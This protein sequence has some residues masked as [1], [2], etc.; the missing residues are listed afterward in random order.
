MWRKHVA[1][2]ILVV[3]FINQSLFK[4]HDSKRLFQ[5]RIFGLGN[6]CPENLKEVFD[7]I[8]NKC[9]GLLLAIITISGLLANKAQNGIPL[10]KKAQNGVHSVIEWD[11]VQTSIGYGL[12]RDDIVEGILSLSYFDLPYHLK[13]FLLYLSIF[14]E[15]Y[16]I[17]KTRLVWLWVAEG[18]IPAKSTCSLYESGE[19]SFSELI[20]IEV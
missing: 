5:N 14:P 15:D 13:A 16:Y 4:K 1:H 7:K 8:L 20:N 3:G 17:E 19:K 18:F 2:Y 9:G 10:K 6:E 12:E 11:Q